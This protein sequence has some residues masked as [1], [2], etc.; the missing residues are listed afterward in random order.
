LV[1]AFAAGLV[2]LT[3]TRWP[4]STQTLSCPPGSVRVNVDGVATCHG[5]EALQPGQAL[6]VEQKVDL[7]LVTDD[8]LTLL[9]GLNED[10][11]QAIVDARSRL[12]GFRTW[13]QVDAVEGVG[14]ARLAVLQRH[15]ELGAIDAGLW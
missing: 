9:P 1:L 14:P 12:G 7:N 15:C 6:T 4:T 11:A 2:A 3:A 13:A 5:G 8:E 10:V